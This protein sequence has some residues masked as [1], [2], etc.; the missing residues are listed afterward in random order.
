MKTQGFP[1]PR[2]SS[3]LF[4]YTAQISKKLHV[5]RVCPGGCHRRCLDTVADSSPQEEE[6]LGLEQCLT[7]DS[8]FSSLFTRPSPQQAASLVLRVK[9]YGFGASAPTEVGSGRI[10][11]HTSAQPPAP[12]S[13]G[14][15]FLQ[16]PPYSLLLWEPSSP[17][18]VCSAFLART[19]TKLLC[20]IF[21][22]EQ[23]G[24]KRSLDG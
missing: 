9:L 13:P 1:S 22:R 6:G 8:T 11:C 2:C 14:D 23:E 19:H 12:V 21:Y 15:A 10:R 5:S 24:G 17:H 20:F 4:G 18:P 16:S 3:L 7:A